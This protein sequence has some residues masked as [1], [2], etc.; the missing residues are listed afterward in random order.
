MVGGFRMNKRLD[1]NQVKYFLQGLD[2]K[3]VFIAVVTTMIIVYYINPLENVALDQWD[4]TFSAAMLSGISIGKRTQ[5]F[6]VLFLV[7]I[8]VILGC[9]IGGYGLLLQ[10]RENYKDIFFKMCAV[11]VFPIIAAY[12]SRYSTEVSELNLNKILILTMASFLAVLVGVSILDKH[13]LMTNGHSY[14]LSVAYMVAI[15]SSNILLRVQTLKSICIMAMVFCVYLIVILKTGIGR[16]FFFCVQNFIC[17]LMWVPCLICVVLEGF[18]FLN[19]KN[20][21]VV[22]YYTNICKIVFIYM[23]IAAVVVFL[24]RDKGKL[25]CIFGYVGAIT[26]LAALKHFSHVYQYI[27]NYINYS[28]IYEVGNATVAV[29]TILNG[30]LPI[31]DYFS[32]H[33]L[34]DVWPNIVY[35]FLHSDIKGLLVNPYGGLASLLALLIL[36]F[37]L[38]NMFDIH[39]VAFF[40]CVF[41]FSISSVKVTSLCFLIIVLLICILNVN[42]PKI[43]NFIP[44]WVIALL[45]A[46]VKY[47]EGWS[48]GIACIIAYIIINFIQ[49]RWNNIKNFLVAGTEIGVMALV[50]YFIYCE[51]NGILPISRLKEWISVSL[52]SNSTWAT[53]SFGD[54]STLEFLL[55]YFIAP[56]CAVGILIISV[57]QFARK[58]KCPMLAGIT[59][60]FAI[61]EILYIPRSI[62]FNN[63]F[64]SQ[65]I[66]GVLFNF[67]HWT[68]SSFVL[69]ELSIR[70]KTDGRKLLTWMSSLGIVILAEG[71]L[72]TGVL[73]TANSI[74]Y[75]GAAYNAETIKLS[76][77]MS[78]LRG[79]ERIVY[80]EQ[81][82]AFINQFQQV[83]DT[84]LDEDET[85]LDFANV[86]SLYMLTGRERPFY[87]GQSP[88]L[89]TDLNSQKCFLDEISQ[90]KVPL[91]VL[92]TT[93]VSYTQQMV[94]VPH[95]IRYYTIA[96]YIYKNYRP[97]I[98]A[99]DF[100]IWCEKEVYENF[101]DI[102]KEN[103]FDGKGYQFVDYGYDKITCSL[104]E[105]ER[106]DYRLF[107][108]FALGMLPYIWANNDNYDAI[109]NS[110]L[111]EIYSDIPNFYTFKGSQY[112]DSSDGNYV[113]FECTNLGKDNCSVGVSFKDSRKKEIFFEYNFTVVPGTNS[114]IIRVSQD[115]FWDVFNIDSIEFLDI[116]ECV[117]DNVR[118]L[119][120]D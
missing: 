15:T 120:G 36:F 106:T 35:C 87:V 103:N 6:F 83:F 94:S 19:E 86:T 47:D 93:D 82:V 99:G 16:R 21:T 90:Y 29:D 107:H 64:V 10:A 118:I 7:V 92:G 53:L 88:S 28:N 56:M 25:F 12:I 102:L 57:I 119:E 70:E 63:L 26:S 13:S 49:K 30:K 85:F 3:T 27:W 80:D 98:L 72:V 108:Q 54:S 73:P 5:H 89:L 11:L 45:V 8:P 2:A 20:I 113:A 91:A 100:A 52:G 22:R 14:I 74:L 71:A 110:K 112:V 48:L 51:F 50:I 37:I 111:V 46:F 114:Y 115:Y 59:M 68:I 117:L 66:T 17:L 104:R 61:A 43:S 38:K 67:I 79:Q 62:T 31:I 81:T 18:F 24:L 44:F 60:T 65:G 39:I 101:H 95:N 84:L 105:T 96:E 69:Y 97:L 4:R 9:V 75:A 42:V 32:A 34:T 109:T 77:D 116:S 55:S 78:Y 33:A 40:I 23:V 76:N 41:P 1:Q 58:K